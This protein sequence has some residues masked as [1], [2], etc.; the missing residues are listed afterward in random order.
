MFPEVL[1][2]ILLSKFFK[3]V[4]EIFFLSKNDKIRLR[5]KCVIKKIGNNGGEGI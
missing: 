4:T 2:M 5:P 3:C 1:Q